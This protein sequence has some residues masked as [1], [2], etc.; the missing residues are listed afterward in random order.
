MTAE[1][2]RAFKQALQIMLV[3]MRQKAAQLLLYTAVRTIEARRAEWAVLLLS[4]R[5]GAY[6]P[7]R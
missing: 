1:Q 6:L 3:A 4:P 5:F 2:I 7:T